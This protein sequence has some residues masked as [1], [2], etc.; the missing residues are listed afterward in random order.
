MT[1]IIPCHIRPW[2]WH[3]LWNVVFWPDDQSSR[4][5]LGRTL[6]Q[7]HIVWAGFST[8]WPGCNFLVREIRWLDNWWIRSHGNFSK[9]KSPVFKKW[10]IAHLSQLLF[11]ACQP[12][13]SCP[14]KGIVDNKGSISP[15]IL[16]PASEKE[17]IG[18][19]SCH[20]W[21]SYWS[22]WKF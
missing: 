1:A 5:Y 13:L 20:R 22:W 8:P 16:S 2:P 15:K 7:S 4:L 10:L 21:R 6:S 3:A 19:W 17:Y 18:K 12:L 9:S 11:H 14:T